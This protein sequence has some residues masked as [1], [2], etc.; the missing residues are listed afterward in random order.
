VDQPNNDETNYF[1]T[2]QLF[3]GPHRRVPNHIC[4]VCRSLSYPQG[5]RKPCFQTQHVDAVRAS[6]DDMAVATIGCLR[7][8][9]I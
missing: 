6:E 8:R 2:T 9:W 5:H 7:L 1:G 3:E 4:R